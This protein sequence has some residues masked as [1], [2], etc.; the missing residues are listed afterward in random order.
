[1]SRIFMSWAAGAGRRSLAVLF[2]LSVSLA[3]C[4]SVRTSSERT[5][6]GTVEVNFAA[7]GDSTTV[8]VPNAEV[9]LV[10]KDGSSRLLGFTDGGGYVDYHLPES[11]V[12]RT[13]LILVCHRD[14]CFCGALTH[15]RERMKGG[16]RLY[17]FLA[18]IVVY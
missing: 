13:L 11:D 15:A 6:S 17:I 16:A 18:P 10:F 12:E 9:R 2:V 3:G 1:M 7:C 14:C 4:S 5:V 8:P